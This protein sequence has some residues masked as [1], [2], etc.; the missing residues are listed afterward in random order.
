MNEAQFTTK[1][2]KWFY[3]KHQASCA[4][5]VKLTKTQSIPFS[6]LKDHQWRNLRAC[7]IG[8]TVYKIPDTGNVQMPFDMV[9]LVKVPAYIAVQ[10]YKRGEKKFYLIPPLTWSEMRNKESRKSVTEEMLKRYG[11]YP[12]YLH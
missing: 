3:Y 7:E 12:Q 8:Q 9:M 10:F 2:N 5:E 11:I 6:V 1:L 4:I